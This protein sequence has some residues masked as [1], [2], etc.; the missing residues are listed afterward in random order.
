MIMTPNVIFRKPSVARAN[1]LKI[2]YEQF[3]NP[4][5]SPLLSQPEVI[6]SYGL[7]IVT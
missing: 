6:R 7:I 4:D 5:A 2:A 3:G 1:G